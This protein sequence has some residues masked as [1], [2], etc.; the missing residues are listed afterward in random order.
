MIC[1]E[2]LLSHPIKC[3]FWHILC[4]FF[5]TLGT[6]HFPSNIYLP[7]SFFMYMYMKYILSFHENDNIRS[8]CI[9]G[10]LTN[11]TN[12]NLGVN[13]FWTIFTNSCFLSYQ[14]SLKFVNYLFVRL[15]IKVQFSKCAG[16]SLFCS[17]CKFVSWRERQYSDYTEAVEWNLDL[18]CSVCC[19][20]SMFPD[21][22]DIFIFQYTWWTIRTII[23]TIWMALK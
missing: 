15:N 1:L 22:I 10:N 12:H 4:A 5:T 7:H 2:S 3:N 9:W 23:R 19:S 6:F 16:L 8:L 14:I 13:K 17:S 21:S 20:L 18:C 11:A